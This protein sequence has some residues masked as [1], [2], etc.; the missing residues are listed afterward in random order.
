MLP[1][2]LH[3]L[4]WAPFLAGLGAFSRWIVRLFSLVCRALLTGL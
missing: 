2:N 3:A 4:D 1:A